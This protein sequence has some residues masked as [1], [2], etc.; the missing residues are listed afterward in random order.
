VDV[1]APLV[2]DLQPAEAVEPRTCSFH[3][4][5]VTPQPLARLDAPAG[6]AWCDASP[7]QLGSKWGGVISLVGVQLL[8]ALARAARPATLDRLDARVVDVG[9]AQR[10]RERDARGFDHKMALRARFASIRRTRAGFGAPPTAG[11][12]KE[13]TEALDQSS[14]SE[15]ARRSKSTWCNRRQ[16]PASCHSLS[17]RQ[18]VVPDPQPSSGGSHDHG[19]LARRTKMMPRR[20]SRFEM[21]GLPP[22]GFSGSGGSNGSTTAHNSSLT[23][24]FAIMSDFINSQLPN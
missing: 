18:Q 15:S 11:I 13:S 5:A 8:G 19:R 23:M 10:D 3:D 12:V 9:R 7:A 17:L 4:P 20:Q 21:R 2:P 14:W 6:D 1:G 16:T 24:G 22:L